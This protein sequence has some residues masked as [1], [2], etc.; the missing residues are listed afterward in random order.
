MGVGRQK[1]AATL[2]AARLFHQ[3]IQ[4][5]FLL[6]FFVFV[7]LLFLAFL[8]LYVLLQYK[9]VALYELLQHDTDHDSR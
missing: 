6:A 1:C 9:V 3:S 2:M 5:G 7:I 8:V 4:V